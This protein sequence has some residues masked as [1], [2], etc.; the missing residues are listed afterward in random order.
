MDTLLNAARLRSRGPILDPPFHCPRPPITVGPGVFLNPQFVWNHKITHVI[1]VAEDNVVPEWIKRS[2]NTR[3]TNL[4]IEDDDKTKLE[5]VYPTFERVL[6]Q[7]LRDPTCA[8]VYVNCAAGMNRS[9]SLTAMFLIKHLNLPFEVIALQ[10]LRQRP[11]T[12]ANP[13][14]NTQLME[15]AKK[16]AHK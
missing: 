1:N 15:F 14:F 10:M 2:F 11:C 16:H 4:P 6:L 3:Y 12:L 7:Y 5:N 13:F 9:A 8:R